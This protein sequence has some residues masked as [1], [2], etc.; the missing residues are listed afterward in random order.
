MREITQLEDKVATQKRHSCVEMENHRDQT[1]TVK[2]K[3]RDPRWLRIEVCRDYMRGEKCDRGDEQCRF[4]HPDDNCLVVSGKVT[5]CYDSMKGR[6]NRDNCKYYHPPEHLK[7]YIQALGKAFEQQRLAEEQSGCYSGGTMPIHIP[8]LGPNPLFHIANQSQ[9]K[10]PRRLDFSDKLPICCFFVNNTCKKT[11][12]DCQFAHPPPSVDG[13]P[14]GFVT[15]CM[16]FI[17]DRCDRDNCRYFHPPSHLKARVKAVQLRHVPI[18]PT[19]PLEGSCPESAL[20]QQN[21]V[22]AMTTAPPLVYSSRMS[23]VS[24]RTPVFLYS[25]PT[26]LGNITFPSYGP[27][28][29][30][31]APATA[32]LPS[33][34]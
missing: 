32:A 33:V 10:T 5:A 34:H 27:S 25:M 14:N 21:F 24:E 16:D 8:M 13:D 11:Q 9:L 1:T 20:S 4:A 7:K 6:C 12:D 29:V 18:S 30:L 3:I 28:L 2:G 15:V 19:S 31:N 22:P 23:Y 26:P 17:S